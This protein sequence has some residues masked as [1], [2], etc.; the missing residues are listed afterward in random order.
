MRIVK[1]E[2]IYLSQNEA[3]VFRKFGEILDGLERECEKP[4]TVDI[5]FDLQRN[6]ESLWEE[7]EE[8]E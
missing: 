8:V 3:E 5:L 6:L 1:C 7:V 4:K 2:K